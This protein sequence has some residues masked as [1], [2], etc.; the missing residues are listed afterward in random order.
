MIVRA[1]GCLYASLYARRGQWS[2]GLGLALIYQPL[3]TESVAFN[4]GQSMPDVRPS[5]RYRP[6]STA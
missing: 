6:G 4:P 1:C 3:H 2:S 5:A